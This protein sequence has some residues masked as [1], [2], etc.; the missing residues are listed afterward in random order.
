MRTDPAHA[1][2]IIESLEVAAERGGDLTARVYDILFE[3]QPAMRR[4][5]WRDSDGAIKGEML[6]RAFDAII[7]FVGERHYAHRLIQ[8]EVINHEGFDVPREVF[9][10]FFGV[11]LEAVR[12]AC[13][14]AWTPTMETAWRSVLAD[15]DFYVTHPDFAA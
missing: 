9:A 11:M 10:S 3:R 8:S 12:A 14:P 4:L 13:G 1:T 6:S 5:F 2:A 7:D 15:F